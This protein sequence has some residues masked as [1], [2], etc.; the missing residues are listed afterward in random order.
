MIRD[1]NDIRKYLIKA[2]LLK[3]E[4]QK[5]LKLQ[6]KD[7]QIRITFSKSKNDNR[8]SNKEGSSSEGNDV[9]ADIGPLYDSDTVTEEMRIMPAGK[10][11]K[12]HG[13]VGRG[14]LVLF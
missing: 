3:H 1:I 4:I 11:A 8:S 14:V 10:G 2:I 6:S 5:R 13:E 12:A 7:V 9:D